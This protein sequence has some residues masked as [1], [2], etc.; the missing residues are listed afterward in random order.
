MKMNDFD[1]K[2]ETILFCNM[3]ERRSEE[4]RKAISCFDNF[5]V[6]MSPAFSILRQELD[7]MIRVIYLLKIDDINERARLI[8]LTLNGCK[9]NYQTEKLKFSNI[10]D[11]NMVDVSQEV[12]GWTQSVY[13]FGCA[14][15]HLSDFHNH[16]T[17]NPFHKLSA[18]E[19]RNILQHMRH[20]HGGPSHDNPDMKEIAEYIPRIFEKISSNLSYYLD[21]LRK[22]EINFE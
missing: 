13:M 17:Q 10:T 16:I 4:N 7:S 12:Q 9:W 14:F 6:V 21:E 20:Y 11:K 15:I 18:E 3:I 2:N 19:K 1:V 8:K 5:H 22:F